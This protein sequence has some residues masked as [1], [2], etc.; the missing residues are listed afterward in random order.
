MT[1]ARSAGLSSRKAPTLRNL[2]SMTVRFVQPWPRGIRVLALDLSLAVIA[3]PIRGGRHGPRGSSRAATRSSFASSLSRARFVVDRDRRHELR[4]AVIA[5]EPVRDPHQTIDRAR[6]ARRD[7]RREPAA[8]DF[9]PCDLQSGVIFGRRRPAPSQF[10][11]QRPFR[12][13][14]GRAVPLARFRRRSPPP[15]ARQGSGGRA[16]L[17]ARGSTSRR[18]TW[19]ISGFSGGA[20]AVGF[21][22]TKSGGAI[23]APFPLSHNM[24]RAA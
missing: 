1:I 8:R 3:R 23:D 24:P 10:V 22:G 18:A 7:L 5:I 12:R 4:E 14:W 20:S 11:A 17:C 21:D 15:A 13:A 2:R 19:R 6:V 9:E 16:R